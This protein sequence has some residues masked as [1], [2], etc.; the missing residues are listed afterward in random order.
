MQLNHDFWFRISGGDKDT[1]RYAFWAL[2]IPYTSAPRWLSPLGSS[3]NGRFCGYVMLQYDIAKGDK[4]QYLPLFLHAN[5]L[6]HRSTSRGKKI[7][8][9]IKRPRY[10]DASSSSLDAVKT[11]VSNVGGMCVDLAIE[12]DVQTSGLKQE[13]IEEQ[14]AEMN[15]GLFQDVEDRWLHAGGLVAAW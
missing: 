10:D 11:W 14:F 7:F 12:T 3:V 6:K 13:A 2:N 8:R 15:D 5:L 1:F 9:T 4:D